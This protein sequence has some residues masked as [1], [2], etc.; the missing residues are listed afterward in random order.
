MIPERSQT[1]RCPDCRVLVSVVEALHHVC[2][3]SLEA[4]RPQAREGQGITLTPIAPVDVEQ[5]R[6]NG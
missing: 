4:R 1:Y 5:R 6:R 3:E 2:K